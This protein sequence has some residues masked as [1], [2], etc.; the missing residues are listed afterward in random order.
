[1]DNKTWYDNYPKGVA[2]EINTDEY[3]SLVDL[4]AQSFSTYADRTAY[5]Q[6]DS[7]LSY[8]EIDEQSKRFAAYLQ[9]HTNLRQGDRIAIQMPNVSQ[10]PIVMFGALRAGLTVVNTNPLYTP[11]EMEH[12]FNDAG[13]KAIVIMA[14]FADKL[15]KVLPNTDIEHVIISE[16]GDAMPFFKRT[17]VNFVVKNIKKMVPDYH[18][19]AAL[20]L[21]VAMYKGKNA[22]FTPVKVEKTDIAFIQ[23]TGGTTGVA[24]GGILTHENIIA[25]VVQMQAWMSQVLEKGKEIIITPLPMYHIFSLTV[26]VFLFASVGGTNVLIA[27]PRDIP[28]FLKDMGKYPFTVLTGVNT[29]FN[30]M[31]NHEDFAKVDF[32]HLKITIGG[33]MA[34]QSIVAERWKKATG[35]ALTEGYGLTECSPVVA[36][37]PLDGREQ[38]GTIG[39]PMPSTEIKLVDEEGN[40]VKDYEPGELWVR[41]P[42]RMQGYWQRPDETAK[43]ITEDGWLKT[44][45]IAVVQPDGFFKIVD[46]K[47]DMII[48]SGFNVYPNEVEDVMAMHEKVLEVAAIG[49]PDEKS[50]E[51]VKIFVVKKDPSL[52]VEELKAF[53]K[54]NLTGYK[55]PKHY[56][57]KD[58]LP[59]SN[60]GKILRRML[61]D[62]EQEAQAKA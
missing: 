43:T 33:A 20:P 3:S 11:R 19:P 62:A 34:I 54:E 26:N 35:C 1:M 53:A 2:H 17:L 9:N 29:L 5:I 49:V 31:L 56:E 36:C 46:R 4:I 6:M 18:I 44:G 27:N 32:S 10:Y 51:A 55:V 38:I 13:V 28:A 58:E 61:K 30:A 47:K 37:N 52:T 15:Q 16:I 60:V 8:A 21:R 40:E 39:L 42:Q 24:K 7:K 25:N 57:F 48:V 45:D 14:N 22:N 41:G 12:Q 50:T 59:K 23:Y